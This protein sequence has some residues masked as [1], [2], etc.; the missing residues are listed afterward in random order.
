[1]SAPPQQTHE[2]G[3]WPNFFEFVRFVELGSSAALV[4]FF[5][6]F[7]LNNILNK[8]PSQLKLHL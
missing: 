7:F 8:N 1:M 3:F 4:F 6:F 5:F 2:F